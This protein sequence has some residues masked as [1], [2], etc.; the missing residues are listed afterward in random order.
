M[1]IHARYIPLKREWLE[2]IYDL[3][4]QQK[5][6]SMDGRPN[7][8]GIENLLQISVKHGIGISSIPPLEKWV[9]LSYLDKAA[10]SLK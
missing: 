9:D 1:K 6:L 8:K 7:V 4:I 10:A 3:L 2:K 5:M